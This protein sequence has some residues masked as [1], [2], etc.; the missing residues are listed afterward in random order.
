MGR[1]TYPSSLTGARRL[2]DGLFKILRLQT[3][4]SRGAMEQIVRPGGKRRRKPPPSAARRQ[5]LAAPKKKRADVRVKSEPL[6]LEDL[7]TALVTDMASIRAALL[8]WYVEHCRVLPW[9]RPPGS[10]SEGG[11]TDEDFA[12]RVWVSE[13]MLQQTQVV[14]V[15]EYFERWLQRWPTVHD[16]AQVSVDDVRD[17]W[18]GLGYYSRAANLLKGAQFIVETLGGRFPSTVTELR[19]IPGVFLSE[20]CSRVGWAFRCGSLYQSGHCLYRF[21]AARGSGGWKCYSCAFSIVCRFWRSEETAKTLSILSRCLAGSTASWR[22]QS[23][24]HG[25]WCPGVSSFKSTVP[26]MSRSAPLH[27][28]PKHIARCQEGRQCIHSRASSSIVVYEVR[29]GAFERVCVAQVTDYP[30]LAKKRAKREMS[31]AVSVLQVVSDS[32]S[33]YLLLK[34]PKRGL[35]AGLWEFPTVP[36]TEAAAPPPADREKETDAFL[37]DLL[38]Q[39]LSQMPAIKRAAIGTAVHIFSHIRMTLHIEALQFAARPDEISLNASAEFRWVPS[40]EIDS[41][42]MCTMV[43]KVY[44]VFREYQRKH[45]S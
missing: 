40:Q 24:C 8:R 9:R 25:V 28:L 27:G 11:E 13:V 42:G 32:E 2:T 45:Q 21:S 7:D 37:K 33:W 6:E 34:R 23:G 17:M 16:L 43:K 4:R 14:K 1:S 41:I 12:Y 36:L 39:D 19:Q 31:V 22:L 30:M 44:N 35:L 5:N 18:S 29:C 20:G 15:V 3:C 26:R 10:K 38:G